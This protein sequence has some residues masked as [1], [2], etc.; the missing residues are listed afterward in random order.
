MKKNTWI[1]RAALTLSCFGSFFGVARSESL[2][3]GQPAPVFG[4]IAH[5]GTRLDLT[6]RKGLGWTVLYFYPKADTPGCTKQACAFRD[7][8]QMIRDKNAEV[9]GIST[10]SV[11]DLAKFHKKYRLNFPLLADPDASVTE[12]YGVKMPLLRLSKRWTFI[13]DQDLIV[14]AIDKDVDPARDA[15]LVAQKIQELSIEGHASP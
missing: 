8:I 11:A 3:V 13:I 2:E 14:R 4:L 1:R 12:R 6:D 7:R 9:Y 5:D 10:D 15:D